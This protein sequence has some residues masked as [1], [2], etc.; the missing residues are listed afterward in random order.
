MSYF[1]TYILGAAATNASREIHY[2]EQ[3][4]E[5]FIAGAEWCARYLL[6]CVEVDS[7]EDPATEKYLDGLRLKNVREVL[8]SVMQPTPDPKEK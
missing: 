2:N 5:A 1:K 8:S 6:R 3:K 4:R 7:R